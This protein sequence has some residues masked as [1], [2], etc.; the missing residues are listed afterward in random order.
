MEVWRGGVRVDGYGDDGLPIYGGEVD[1][2]ATKQVRRTLT[3]VSVDATDA[4]W[5]LLSPVG[6]QLR[7]FRGF[8]YLNSEIEA[9]PVGQFVLPGLSETYGGNWSGQIGTASDLMSLVQRARFATPR[10]IPPGQ[11]ISGVIAGLIGEVL[12]NVTNLSTSQAVTG[13]GLLYPRDRG[14]AIGELSASIG[15]D[16]F[17]APDGTPTIRDTPQLSATSVWTVDAGD[18]GILYEAGRERTYDRTY[19]GVQAIP[20]QINGAPPFDPVTV[21]D[22]D[23]LSPTYHLG[24]FGEA[25]YFFESPLFGDQSQAFAAATSLLPKV[26]AVRAQ[27][28]LTAECNP[29]LADGDTITVA[30][31]PRQRGGSSITERHLVSTLTIPL[32]PD[33]TQKIDTASAVADVPDSA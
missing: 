19:S 11:R 25:L 3:N 4:M 23:P 13:S 26:T 12:P 6:T 28:S 31:P 21:W 2:D 20:S 27:M 30:L 1:V 5:D 7:V 15:A 24:P 16:V 10:A 29:A 18:T 32:T 14:G 8:R 22:E 33:G 9:V 17:I